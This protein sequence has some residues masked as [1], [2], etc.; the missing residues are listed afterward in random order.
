M[1]FFN[2]KYYDV[3][4]A[5]DENVAEFLPVLAKGVGITPERKK[6]FPANVKDKFFRLVFHAL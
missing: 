3:G 2:A 1:Y 4:I 6:S 5:N